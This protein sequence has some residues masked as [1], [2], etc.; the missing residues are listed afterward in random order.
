MA[1]K[2]ARV[3]RPSRTE[4]NVLTS[5]ESWA[6]SSSLLSNSE[7]SVTY[8]G[9][10]SALL[11]AETGRLAITVVVDAILILENTTGEWRDIWR[12]IEE[13]ARG[14]EKMSGM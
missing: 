10:L 2:T 5:L 11:C 13:M 7:K 4:S 6:F 8:S 9:L 14:L 1:D 12:W 3:V